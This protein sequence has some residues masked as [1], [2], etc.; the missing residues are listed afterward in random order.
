MGLNLNPVAGIIEAVGKVADDLV[1][2]DAERLQADLAGMAIGLD[3]AKVDADLIKGQQE[4]NKEEAKHASIFVAGARPAIL[5]V[6]V[7][8]LAY[9]FLLYPLMTW[10]W[11][12]FQAQGWVPLA[13][14]PP[15]ILDVDALM[16]LMTG[17]LGIA[18][19]RT[20]E[21]VRGVSN[22]PAE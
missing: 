13:V 3:A 15:P 21:K 9:Q 11:A 2:S 7:V 5:W 12:F 6:G 10:L 4:I 22:R 18:G 1:T 8:S 14:A 20:F 16:V 19:A 17:V